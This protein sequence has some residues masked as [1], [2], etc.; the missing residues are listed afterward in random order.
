MTGTDFT[1]AGAISTA[2]TAIAVMA[3]VDGVQSCV[4]FPFPF[5]IVMIA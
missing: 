5:N 1:N 4:Y 2:V 3:S